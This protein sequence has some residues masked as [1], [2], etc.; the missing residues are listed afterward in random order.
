M[1]RHIRKLVCFAESK[2]E[3]GKCFSHFS[4]FLN[5]TTAAMHRKLANK[6]PQ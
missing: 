1:Y 5:K 2:L 3:S 4:E 6:P